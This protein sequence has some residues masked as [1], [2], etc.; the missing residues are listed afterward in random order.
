MPLLV[1]DKVMVLAE[2]WVG[3]EKMLKWMKLMLL[4]LQQRWLQL[5][6]P[7]L[8][9]SLKFLTKQRCDRAHRVKVVLRWLVVFV[10]L[11]NI[12]NM[13]RFRVDLGMCGIWILLFWTPLTVM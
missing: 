7:K 11:N 3:L 12:F 6:W 8:P 2:V 10:S 5:M 4:W 1:M 13:R 9:A